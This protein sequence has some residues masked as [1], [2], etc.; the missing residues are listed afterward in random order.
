LDSSV[1]DGPSISPIKERQQKHGH[2]LGSMPCANYL[3]IL[4]MEKLLA[5]KVGFQRN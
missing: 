2:T 3:E 1:T 5:F 4:G